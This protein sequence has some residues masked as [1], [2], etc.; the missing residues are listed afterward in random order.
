VRTGRE[1]GSADPVVG[2]AL[3]AGAFLILS[4]VAVTSWGGWTGKGVLPPTPKTVPI[5]ATACP[6]VRAVHVTASAAGQGWGKIDIFS[7]DPKPWR[8]FAS[9]LRPKLANLELALRITIPHVPAPVAKNLRVTLTEVR[10]GRSKLDQSVSAL[11]YMNRT[12][13][14]VFTGYTSL[15]DASDLVGHACGVTLAPTVTLGF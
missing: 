13:E 3:V 14:A 10:I 11:D 5:R 9:Q 6:Y 8:P 15:S 1:R 12:D 7:K 4:L 2:V